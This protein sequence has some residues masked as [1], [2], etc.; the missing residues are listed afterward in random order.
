MKFPALNLMTLDTP[1]PNTVSLTSTTNDMAMTMNQ[2]PTLEAIVGLQ[3]SYHAAQG[4]SRPGIGTID[5]S[6]TQE[7]AYNINRCMR[8]NHASNENDAASCYDRIIT[9]LMSLINRA[10]GM[11]KSWV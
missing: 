5:I 11:P 6:A 9:S 3:G 1:S 4:G 8:T 7:L 10:N 2:Q